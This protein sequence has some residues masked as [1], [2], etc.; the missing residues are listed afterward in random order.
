[1]QNSQIPELNCC[2]CFF[3]IFAILH[4]QTILS[5][6][7]LV[8]VYWC[9]HYLSVHGCAHVSR[10]SAHLWNGVRKG[11]K[12]SKEKHKSEKK[13]QFKTGLHAVVMKM[14]TSDIKAQVITE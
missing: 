12:I 2:C 7:I 10:R 8:C 14:M 13:M 3:A 11:A 4:I 9:V 5:V 6:C 1:M